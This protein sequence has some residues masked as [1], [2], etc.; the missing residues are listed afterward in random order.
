MP[1]SMPS[2]LKP[3]PAITAPISFGC[4]TLFA[5]FTLFIG[6]RFI[7]TPDA[8]F[9]DFGLSPN[10]RAASIGPVKGVRDVFMAVLFLTFAWLADQRAL[11]LCALWGSIIP[12]LDGWIAATEGGGLG[13]DWDWSRALQHW[14]GV[15]AF[16]WHIR[17]SRADAS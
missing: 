9:R 14:C 17:C 5:L 8:A 3:S 6:L 15:Q 16:S 7:L 12:A 10:P 11:G 1:S 4:M 2:F 13:V